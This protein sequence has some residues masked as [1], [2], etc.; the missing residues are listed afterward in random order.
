MSIELKSN[1]L[2]EVEA[3]FLVLFM[4]SCHFCNNI[5]FVRKALQTN[6]PY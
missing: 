3:Y 5:I 2:D 4:K 1:P 6:V